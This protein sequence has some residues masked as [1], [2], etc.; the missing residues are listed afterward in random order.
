VHPIA[1]TAEVSIDLPDKFYKSGFGR[2]S[3]F[4]A[5]AEADDVLI[6]LVRAGSVCAGTGWLRLSPPCPRSSTARRTRLPRS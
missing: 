5:L 1:D 2:D 6:R 3:A 4:E